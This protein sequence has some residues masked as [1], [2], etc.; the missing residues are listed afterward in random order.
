VQLVEGLKA[1]TGPMPTLDAMRAGLKAE[2]KTLTEQLA[3]LNGQIKDMET[4]LK[5]A[6]EDRAAEHEVYE[7]TLK[8]QMETESLLTEALGVLK[9]VYKSPVDEFVQVHKKL[10]R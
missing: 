8:D 5:R 4:Q 3:D 9:G 10:H 6:K 7:G 1:P 2:V